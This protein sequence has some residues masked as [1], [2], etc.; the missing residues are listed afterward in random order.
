MRHN[1]YMNLTTRRNLIQINEINNWYSSQYNLNPKKTSKQKVA[2][3]RKNYAAGGQNGALPDL[4]RMLAK[5]SHA[6]HDYQ[7]ALVHAT[8]ALRLRKDDPNILALMKDIAE[9][10]SRTKEQADQVVRSVTQQAYNEHL[11]REEL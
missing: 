11:Q 5:A 6:E 7:Q 1:G 9:D 8:E 10:G 4:Y 3:V 2:P